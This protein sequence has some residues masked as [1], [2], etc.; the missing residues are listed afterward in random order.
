MKIIDSQLHCFYPDTPQRPWPAGATPVHGPSF[1][2]EQA[3]ELLDKHGVQGAVLV[4]PSWNGWDNQYSQDAAIA[5]PKRFAVM[6]RF[7]FEA[8]DAKE[9]LRHWRSQSG[10]NGVRLFV[11]GTPWMQLLNPEYAWVWQIAE[12]T[13]LP[14]MSTIP[15]NIAGFEP[16]LAQFPE[17][18]L[19]IDHAGRHPRG[20]MDDGAWADADALYALA[21]FKNVSVKVSSLP[22]FSTQPY[23]FAN[24]HVH[25]KSIYD[26]FGPQRM[27]WGSDATRLTCTYDENIRLFTEAMDFL[28]AEDKEWIMGRSIANALDWDI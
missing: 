28:S 22:C 3:T 12:E 21:R 8:P 7:D 16:I 26:K 5:Q 27:M 20:A 15:G 1:T 6:G 25:I 11:S 24:L 19:I 17:L 4:P 23:P 18:R 2:I 10:M 13:R 14:V 9:R